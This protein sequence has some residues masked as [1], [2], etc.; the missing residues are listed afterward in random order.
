MQ[1]NEWFLVS[2]DR[3]K[4]KVEPCLLRLCGDLKKMVDAVEDRDSSCDYSNDFISELKK[5]RTIFVPFV[6]PL[7]DMVKFFQAVYDAR[8]N[9]LLLKGICA[10]FERD[11]STNTLLMMVEGFDIALLKGVM[12]SDEQ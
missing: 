12:S 1:R 6:I 5:T 11:F 9:K 3:V 10:Q 2:N 7:R 8:Q 4:I